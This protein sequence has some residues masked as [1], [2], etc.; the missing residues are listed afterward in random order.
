VAVERNLKSV[1]NNTIMEIKCPCGEM[2]SEDDCGLDKTDVT[3]TL[4]YSC[5]SCDATAEIGFSVD[6]V[7]VTDGEGNTT[8]PDIHD[9]IG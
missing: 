8:S 1:V 3:F 5:Y 2:M 7:S 9:I 6:D 4:S